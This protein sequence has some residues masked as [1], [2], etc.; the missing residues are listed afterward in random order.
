MDV[1]HQSLARYRSG[2]ALKTVDI[3]CVTVERSSLCMVYF[4]GDA[5]WVSR[6]LDNIVSCHARALWIVNPC[7]EGTCSVAVDDAGQD[8][9]LAIL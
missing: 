4:D 5:Y 3:R 9:C 2:R 8:D 7:E 1:H 6:R